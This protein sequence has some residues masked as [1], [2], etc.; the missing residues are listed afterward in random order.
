M[1]R[2][3]LVGLPYSH[4]HYLLS[5]SKQRERDSLNDQRI[6]G[7]E[8]NSHSLHLYIHFF[9][10]PT[11][12]SNSSAARWRNI[13]NT[14]RR[15]LISKVL[16]FL[17]HPVGN[18]R[19]SFHIKGIGSVGSFSFKT[20]AEDP[21]IPG[22]G[23]LKTSEGREGRGRCILVIHREPINHRCSHR[24]SGGDW[25]QSI[26]VWWRSM[27]RSTNDAALWCSWRAIFV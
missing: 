26:K 1:I 7:E 4:L 17:P 18:P 21:R 22:H 24:R 3:F 8:G 23:N 16:K 13:P 5:L 6:Y 15:E 2:R 20:I 19:D 9:N 12:A 25:H 27:K 10:L 11:W 14:G